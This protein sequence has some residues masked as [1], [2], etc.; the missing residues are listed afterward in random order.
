ML[1]S[2]LGALGG[3]SGIATLVQAPISRH[4]IAAEAERNRVDAVR[5]MTASAASAAQQLADLRR[6]WSRPR[7]RRAS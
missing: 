3:L 7:S 5:P 4:K 2:V 6:R 1:A